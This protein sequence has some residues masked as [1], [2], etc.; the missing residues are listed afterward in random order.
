[1]ITAATAITASI[2][3]DEL[4]K[5][6]TIAAIEVYILGAELDESEVNTFM[7]AIP[8]IEKA[9]ELTDNQAGEALILFD[10]L[11]ETVSQA[12]ASKME[13][14]L[15]EKFLMDTRSGDEMHSVLNA[16]NETAEK[17]DGVEEREKLAT[18]I[19]YLKDFWNLA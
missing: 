3:V 13:S 9:W 10:I 2:T 19:R 1:M 11:H 5:K 15:D 8:L 17:L 18:L 16:L 12:D 14:A 4:I 6:M 7:D